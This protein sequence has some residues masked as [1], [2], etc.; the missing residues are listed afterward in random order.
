MKKFKYIFLIVFF[1]SIEGYS[2][3]SVTGYTN[4]VLGMNTNKHK[5]ISFEARVFANNY[6]DELPMELNA[7]Y[8]FKTTEYHRFSVGFGMNVSPFRGFDE[9]N[10]IVFPTSLEIF[11]MK[12]FKRIAV[13]FELTP[14]IR[15]EDDIVLRSLIGIRYSF[16]KKL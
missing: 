11:P 8:N 4:Y 7:F 15:I 6:V 14:E 2:Q 16:N 12:D 1:L 3:I 10:S 9:I 13:V 5:T